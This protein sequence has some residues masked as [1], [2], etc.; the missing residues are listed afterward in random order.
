M[1]KSSSNRH[2]VKILLAIAMA[3]ASLYLLFSPQG[4]VRYARQQKEMTK[5]RESNAALTLETSSL[6][7]EVDRL[8]SD[9]TYIEEVAR[10]KGFLK[11]N[12]IYYEFPEK[13]K[14]H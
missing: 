2:R 1:M 9:P 11:K 3:L 10:N 6:R 5:L 13:K 12:E 4:I 7:Q 8:K 14:H